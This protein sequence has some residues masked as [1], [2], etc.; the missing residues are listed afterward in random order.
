MA[1]KNKAL[2]LILLFAAALRVWGLGWGLPHEYQSEEYKIV[3]YALRMG[4]GDLNPHF[5]EYPSLYLYFMLFIYGIYFGIGKIFGWFS[6][7]QDFALH[8]VKD[9]TAF[10]LLGRISEMVCGVMI[11]FMVYKIG[12]KLFSENA[13]LFAAAIVAGLP[14]FVYL[15]HIIKG[16]MGMTLLLLVSFWFCIRILEEGAKKSYLFAGILMGLAVSTRYHAAPFG[17]VIPTA[18]FLRLFSKGELNFGNLWD[19]NKWLLGA[20][21]LIPAFF[22]AGTPYALIA[23]HELWRDFGGN[24]AIYSSLTGE[25]RS[26]FKNM[27]VLFD[28][29]LTLG[30]VPAPRI[31]GIVCLIGF[32]ASFLRWQAKHFLI[33]APLAAYLCIV[34]G[35]HNPAGGY[36]IQIFPLF[37]L[38]SVHGILEIGGK[39]PRMILAGAMALAVSWNAWE[40]AAMAYSFTASDTR[41]TALEWIEKNIPQG[42]SFLIDMKVTA[43]PLRMS[44]EQLEKFHRRAIE[45]GHYKKDILALELKA[46]P[47]K[48]TGYQIYTVKRDF[49]RIGS[50]PNQVEEVQKLQDLIE[51]SGDIAAIKK[52]GVQYVVVTEDTE[53]MAVLNKIH[54]LADFYRNLPAQSV[55]LEKFDP[56]F[57][58]RHSGTIYIYKL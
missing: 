4:S 28:R 41:T 23:P 29:F 2:L 27:A 39:R 18:H 6:A 42:S 8:F 52:A 1:S 43:P 35:Y 46:H 12:K 10:Y 15:S 24:V 50:L 11:V 7:P 56:Q 26:I 48:G 49:G 32:F 51:V 36:L 31:M 58:I 20:L 19:R 30:D 47:G 57:R 37:I 44:Y 16:Y 13:G 54:G 21:V 40:G 34:G 55:M 22:V 3:K 25:E 5:F 33:L 53:K 14:H 38:L 17:I 9:P 45:L